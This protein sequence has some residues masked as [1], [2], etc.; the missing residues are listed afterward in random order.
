MRL[1]LPSTESPRGARGLRQPAWFRCGLWGLSSR[2]KPARK[3][4]AWHPFRVLASLASPIL[5]LIFISC[6]LLFGGGGPSQIAFTHELFGD[7]TGWTRLPK[8]QQRVVN[9]LRQVFA[10][11]GMLT[12]LRLSSPPDARA[13]SAREVIIPCLVGLAAAS[14]N[15]TLSK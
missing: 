14:S 12:K 11:W 4:P 10:L 3:C 13:P 2:S 6:A 15:S 5:E 7:D 8:K 9:C 1:G